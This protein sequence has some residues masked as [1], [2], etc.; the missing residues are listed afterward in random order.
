[1]AQGTGTITSLNGTVAATTEGLSTISF[2]TSGTWVAT[3]IIEAT[4]DDSNWFS[5]QGINPSTTN[6]ITTF[7]QN[8]QVVVPC[9]GFS[10]IRLRASAFTSGTVTIAWDAGDGTNLSA[11]QPVKLTN[12][13]ATNIAAVENN[14]SVRVQNSPSQKACFSTSI[15]TTTPASAATDFL[16]IYGATGKVVRILSIDISGTATALADLKVFLIKRSSTNTGGTSSAQTAVPFDSGNTALA[17]IKLY[18]ANPTSLGTAVGTV[19]T[20][21]LLLGG[22]TTVTG[23]QLGYTFDLTLNGFGSGVK[24][25]TTSEGLAVNFNG[26]TLPSGTSIV[27]CN[28]IWIEE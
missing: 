25:L 24:L 3:I 8:L 21:N 13:T 27:T 18:T 9:G 20:T 28:V 26:A 1:M 22:V 14:G 19:A 17:T 16:T 12:S 10:Q 7:S 23:A 15:A 6:V 11:N 4:C 2:F 5:V